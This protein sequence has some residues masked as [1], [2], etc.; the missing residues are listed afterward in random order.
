[1]MTAIQYLM[2]HMAPV[3][4]THLDVYKRQADGLVGILTLDEN[5]HNIEQLDLPAG[6]YYVKEL[7]TNV[8][9]VLD[10]DNHAFTF[11]YGE[12]SL[13]SIQVGMVLH[14]EKRRLDLE[15]NKVESEH[16]D[17]FLNGAI[18]EVYDKTTGKSVSYT[19]RMM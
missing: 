10:E 14:N 16:K 7:E 8:G 5:G 11:E 6:D 19:H 12:T 17:H 2:E 9:F 3:S 15:V 18:F 1:M 13:E 4:Y